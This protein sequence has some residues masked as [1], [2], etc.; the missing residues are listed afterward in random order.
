MI[1]NSALIVFGIIMIL[2]ACS[3][4]DKSFNDNENRREKERIDVTK[5]V[6]MISITGNGLGL[7]SETE[8]QLKEGKVVFKQTEEIEVILK[9]I[10]D[11]S[12]HSGP[13]TDEGENF[14]L[15]LSYKDDTTDIILLWLY[16]D[17]NSGRIQRENYTGPMYL[18]SKKD[19]Q[20]IVNLIDKKVSQ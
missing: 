13:M 11:A 14:Q 6:N 7:F 2:A 18:L 19:V 12:A 8:D 1:K 5:D 15:V 16:P 17:R 10:K 9:A 20:I 4:E 3:S